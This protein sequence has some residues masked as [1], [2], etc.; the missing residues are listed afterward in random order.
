MDVKFKYSIPETEDILHLDMGGLQDDIDYSEGDDIIDILRENVIDKLFS[1]AN[2]DLYTFLEDLLVCKIDPIA[3]AG[4]KD[5][6]EKENSRKDQ[7]I[8]KIRKILEEFS[9]ESAEVILES[10]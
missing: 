1:D 7:A 4:I 2:G 3:I 10:L 9:P 6:L 8:E 5:S